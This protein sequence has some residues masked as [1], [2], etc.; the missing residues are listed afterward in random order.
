MRFPTQRHYSQPCRQL[1]QPAGWH[2]QKV[3]SMNKSS[4]RKLAALLTILLIP[5]IQ[6]LESEEIHAK[7]NNAVSRG[8]VGA[9]VVGIY[10]QGNVRV[11]GYGQK[12]PGE[13]QKPDGETLFEIGSITKVFTAILV[14]SSDWVGTK[15]ASEGG[16]IPDSQYLPQDLYGYAN[17]RALRMRKLAGAMSNRQQAK[18][19]ADLETNPERF[20]ESDTRT[21]FE[22]DLSLPKPVQTTKR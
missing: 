4:A 5:E 11:F 14:Q 22:R 8:S 16:T 17:D 3:F 7:I 21:A 2:G 13:A 9:A 15:I 12:N 6:A 18:I 1:K 10:D 20:W 19:R